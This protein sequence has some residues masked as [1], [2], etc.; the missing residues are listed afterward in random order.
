MRLLLD[1]HVLIWWVL[2]MPRLS[3][4]ARAALGDFDNEISVSAA[5]VWEIVT[6]Y[7]TGKLPEVESYIHKLPESLSK[8]GFRELPVSVGHAYRAGMLTAIH[9]DPFDR[10]LIAQAMSENLFLVSNEKVFDGYGIQR[11]W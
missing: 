8:M 10:L 6:K 4:P 1:T 2:D 7:R 11:L 3:E 9:K 5:T